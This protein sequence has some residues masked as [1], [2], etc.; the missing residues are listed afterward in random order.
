M[1]LLNTLNMKDR[2]K[3]RQ[4]RNMSIQSEYLENNREQANEHYKQHTER[5]VKR[6]ERIEKQKGAGWSTQ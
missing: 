5:E 3:L 4:Q 1:R 6:E 2:D